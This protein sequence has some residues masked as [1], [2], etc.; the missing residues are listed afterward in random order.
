MDKSRSKQEP[1]PVLTLLERVCV[2]SHC[3]C[4]FWIRVSYWSFALESFL[5]EPLT[6]FP[7]DKTQKKPYIDT[8]TF[9]IFPWRLTTFVMF[10]ISR[11]GGGEGGP[12]LH[13]PGTYFSHRPKDCLYEND[14]Q[15]A[16]R[17]ANCK[18][19]IFIFLSQ[20]H[21]AIYSEYVLLSSYRK[22]NSWTHSFVQVS[23]Q[24]L[25]SS[26]TWGF[27]VQCLHY[28]PVSNHFAPG[29]GGGGG[30]IVL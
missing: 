10:S 12:H 7:A 28:K 15:L 22:T 17:D 30:E 26:Q 18:Y 20:L 9:G 13:V 29:G 2:T 23:G 24:N 19:F 21:H 27:Q 11:K 5:E 8:R 16:K 14:S 6:V 3:I 25:E 4:Q 1:L